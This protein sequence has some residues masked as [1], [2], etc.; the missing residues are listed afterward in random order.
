MTNDEI[1]P[2]PIQLTPIPWGRKDR[3]LGFAVCAH[4]R[5]VT[6]PTV[7][8]WSIRDPKVQ[9]TLHNAH[10]PVRTI[11]DEGRIADNA[12]AYK[13]VFERA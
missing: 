8:P 12:M 6:P 10:V 2:G 1:Y 13:G 9:R 5:D 11:E 7:I 4:V 3:N